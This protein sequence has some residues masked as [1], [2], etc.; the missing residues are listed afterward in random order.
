[1]NSREP[2]IVLGKIIVDFR[3]P[4]RKVPWTFELSIKPEDLRIDTIWEGTYSHFPMKIGVRI[5]HLPTGI[6]TECKNS[7]S[8]FKNKQTAMEALKKALYEQ[9][10]VNDNTPTKGE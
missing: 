4:K 8:E 9:Y 7:R 10:G 2:C 1:M 3:E 6:V 5:T